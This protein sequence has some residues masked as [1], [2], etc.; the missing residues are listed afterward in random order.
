M[1]K[2]IAVILNEAGK[3]TAFERGAV[4]T[5]FSKENNVWSVVNEI[6]YSLDLTSNISDIRNSIKAIL[7]Q[8]EDCKVIIGETITGLPYNILDRLGFEIYE[9]QSVSDSL[10]EEIN[11]ELE[12]EAAHYTPL[13][14]E[15]PTVPVETSEQGVFFL[16]LIMLQE[17]RPEISSKKAL[18]PFFETCCFY[19]LDL[20]CSH[21]P[22]WFDV[23]LPQKRLTYSVEEL[24]KNQLKVSIIKKVC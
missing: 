15:V 13:S 6:R 11:N 3:L 16:N 4:L 2:K 5:V 12:T 21:I 17:K 8:L 20:I 24:E 19:R 23:T 10:L 18:Q 14:S 22:P 7:L 9:A 1:L